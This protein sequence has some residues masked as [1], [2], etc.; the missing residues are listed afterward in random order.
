MEYEINVARPTTDWEKMM[1]RGREWE[2]YF[3]VIVPYGS[4]KKVYDEL[5]EKFPNC[6]LTVTCWQKTGKTYSDEELES[7]KF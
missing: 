5:K 6:R 1:Y 3:R 4:V 2:H 7:C